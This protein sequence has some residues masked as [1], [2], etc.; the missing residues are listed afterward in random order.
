MALLF[1]VGAKGTVRRRNSLLMLI[2]NGFQGA[3]M[4]CLGFCKLWT[5]AYGWLPRTKAT[6]WKVESRSRVGCWN[7]MVARFEGSTTWSQPAGLLQVTR[8]SPTGQQ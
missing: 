1:S 5:A 6:L 2:R 3:P 8:H 7:G 4:L